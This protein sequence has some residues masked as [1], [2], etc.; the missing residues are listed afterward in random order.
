MFTVDYFFDNEDYGSSREVLQEE[1]DLADFKGFLEF[2][3]SRAARS[4]VREV[5]AG[6]MFGSY[7]T[8]L[9]DKSAERFILDQETKLFMLPI[10]Y[11]WPAR[12]FW[13]NVMWRCRQVVLETARLAQPEDFVELSE[14]V[15][16]IVLDQQ[17]QGEQCHDF[18]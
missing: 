13:A 12:C 15:T 6:C 17:I 18:D 1:K 2:L 14:A 10:Q 7:C 9:F 3:Q 8:W 11:R 5:W 16:Q 4:W